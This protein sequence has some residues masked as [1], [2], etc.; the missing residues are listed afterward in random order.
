MGNNNMYTIEDQR[1]NN[2][3]IDCNVFSASGNCLL[4]EILINVRKLTF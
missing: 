2:K 4:T 1:N 3:C